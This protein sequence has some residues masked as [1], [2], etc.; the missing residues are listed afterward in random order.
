MDEPGSQWHGAEAIYVQPCDAHEL[1]AGI[2]VVV[3]VVVVVEAAELLIQ[4]AVWSE[5]QSPYVTHT[6]NSNAISF[7]T[8]LSML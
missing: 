7:S 6:G 3:V 5:Q 4:T 1:A 2:V 8:K